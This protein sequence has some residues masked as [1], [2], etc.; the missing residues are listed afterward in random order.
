VRWNAGGT[1]YPEANVA[2][3]T[4][5]YP[6]AGAAA[7]YSFAIDTSAVPAS[8]RNVAAYA[9]AKAGSTTTEELQSRGLAA[10]FCGAETA[11]TTKVSSVSID[12][13]GDLV[14]GTATLSDPPASSI[15]GQLALQGKAP[16]ATAWTTLASK[17]VTVA[18]GTTALPYDFSIAGKHT[19]EYRAFAKVN[20]GTSVFSDVVTDATCAPPAEV[21]EAPAAL[22]L[23]LSMA[24]GAGVVV[25]ARRRR[26][27]TSAVSA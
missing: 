2:A 3:S 26:T 23:P 24:A 7:N 8:A 5:I 6:T 25:A 11:V 27:A 10:S 14:N 12:C 17:N 16:G 4:V 18:P 22:L 19:G 20:N 1:T 13:S 15:P 9:I 21:P